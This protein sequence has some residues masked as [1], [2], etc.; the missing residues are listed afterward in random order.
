MIFENLPIDQLGECRRVCKKWQWTIDRLMSFDCLVVYCDQLPINQTL[1][2]SDRR[3]SLQYCI[4]LDHFFEQEEFKKSIY[5]KF[6]KII[7]YDHHYDNFRY[8]YDDN[9]RAGTPAY[10]NHFALMFCRSINFPLRMVSC[11][12]QLE[13][14]HLWAIRIDQDYRLSLPNL[15]TFKIVCDYVIRLDAPQLV[16][17]CLANF[18]CVKLAHPETVENLEIREPLS[19]ENKELI[20]MSHLTGLKRLLIEGRGYLVSNHIIESLLVERIGA[21]LSEINLVWYECDLEREA[22]QRISELKRRANS[23]S[24]YLNGIEVS[25]LL[26]LLNGAS[27]ERDMFLHTS[28]LE[29]REQRDLY[30]SNRSTLSETLPF[31]RVNYNLIEEL[32]GDAL[33]ILSARRMPRLE[34]VIISGPVGDELAFGHWLSRSNALI[35]IIFERPLSQE[36]YSDILPAS[37]PN[38]EG[39]TILNVPADRSLDCSFLLKFRSLYRVDVCSSDYAIVERLFPNLHYLRLLAFYECN[40]RTGRPSLAIVKKMT[41]Y[42]VYSGQRSARYLSLCG[43]VQEFESFEELVEFA[44]K[45]TGFF[46]LDILS[47]HKC[48]H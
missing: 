31:L 46:E 43:H 47:Q 29:S 9:P 15:K 5:R 12:Q 18:Q 14:L 19:E 3:V 8:F 22:Y 7:L 24:I 13:E 34:E 28:D 39:L 37:C 26:H 2:P 44:K 16:N 33:H 32:N 1:F 48:L 41:T 30:L 35:E 4:R 25:C 36:F 17:L 40:N 21:E 38:L 11:L 20:P 42:G 27:Q 10:F 23:I 6:R 45:F